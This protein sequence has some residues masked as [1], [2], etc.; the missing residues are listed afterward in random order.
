VLLP[1]AGTEETIA[2]DTVALAVGLSPRI[3][4]AA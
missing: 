3:E 2:C 4:L 1:V